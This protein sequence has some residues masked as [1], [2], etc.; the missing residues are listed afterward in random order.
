MKGEVTIGDNTLYIRET[1]IRKSEEEEMEVTSYEDSCVQVTGLGRV[2][3]KDVLE[4][5]FSKQGQLDDI[6]VDDETKTAKVTFKHS[7]GLCFNYHI[8]PLSY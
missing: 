4:A 3:S 2:H 1:V 6:T 7:N 8:N 5:Y